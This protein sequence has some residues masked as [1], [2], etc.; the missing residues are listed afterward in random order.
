MI[1][2]VDR[3]ALVAE[4]QSRGVA[5][6]RRRELDGLSGHR[7]ERAVHLAVRRGTEVEA[8]TPMSPAV[9]ERVRAGQDGLC[10]NDAGGLLGVQPSYVRFSK[11]GTNDIVLELERVDLSVLSKLDSGRSFPRLAL[12]RA[13]VGVGNTRRRLS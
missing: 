2:S 6:G 10:L 12:D 13:A 11:E 4:N 1:H 5:R 3:V 7:L 9:E 8:F